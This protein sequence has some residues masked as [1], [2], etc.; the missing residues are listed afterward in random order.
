MASG[1]GKGWDVTVTYRVEGAETFA[2]AREQVG[3]THA[4]PREQ[5]D[6]WKALNAGTDVSV[7]TVNAIRY[8]IRS[9]K[10][11]HRP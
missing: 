3:I 9:L 7:V 11:E 1:I 5:P 8:H 10:E 2:E 4:D 6:I